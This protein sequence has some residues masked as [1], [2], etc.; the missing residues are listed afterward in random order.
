[1]TY[2]VSGGTLNLTLSLKLSV[3]KT[4]LA[5]ITMFESKTVLKCALLS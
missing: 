3:A 4:K 2:T 5:T 1:M